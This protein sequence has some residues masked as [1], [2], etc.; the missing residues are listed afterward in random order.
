[1]AIPSIPA[2]PG[3]PGAELTP[4]CLLPVVSMKARHRGLPCPPSF[5][6]DSI[7]CASVTVQSL[8]PRHALHLGSV[9]LQCPSPSLIRASILA[10]HTAVS[11]PLRVAWCCVM[12][13]AG[14][15]GGRVQRHHAARGSLHRAAGH[16]GTQWCVC[17]SSSTTLQLE[18]HTHTY[19]HHRTQCFPFYGSCRHSCFQGHLIFFLHISG[20]WTVS[21]PLIYYTELVQ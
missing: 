17:K 21:C 1:M 5:K 20:Q 7:H 8:S 3:E 2:S 10:L 12:G 9:T 19:T 14:I 6:A 18:T 16:R 13:T 11:G 15:I 4:D